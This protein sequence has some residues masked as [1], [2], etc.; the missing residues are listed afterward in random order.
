MFYFHMKLKAVLGCRLIITL[1]ALELNLFMFCLCMDFK[2][3]LRCGL[4]ITMD[5]VVSDIF[6]FGLNMLFQILFGI[7]GIIAS[8]TVIS[9]VIMPCSNMNF[10]VLFGCSTVLA[11]IATNPFMFWFH[12]MSLKPFLGFCLII[13]LWAVNLNNFMFCFYV[14]FTAMIS[15]C[16][17]LTIGTIVSL[18]FTSMCLLR[19]C[20]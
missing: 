18:C 6:V 11:M 9:Y 20:L 16:P 2:A 17:E 3:S 14:N 1:W 12:F 5:T 8:F 7:C 4:V 19:D 10:E 15:C 13:T